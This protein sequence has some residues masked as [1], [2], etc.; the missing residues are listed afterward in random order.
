MSLYSL[1]VLIGSIFSFIA[2]CLIYFANPKS[3]NN[4]SFSGFC[5]SLFVWLFGYVIAYSTKDEKTAL[6]FCRIAC[7]GAV[8]TAPT[9]YHFA[10]SFL[11]KRK[12]IK[13]V[14]AAYLAMLFIAP[15][16]LT[17]N[18]FLRG[19]YKYYWG[20]YSKAGILHPLYLIIFFGIF[21]RG[22]YILLIEN[23]K[24]DSSV[25]PIKKVQI[26]YIFIAYAVALMGAI[27][28]V[29]KY[30]V[31]LFPFGFLF[32]ILFVI[33]VAYAIKTR[34]ILNINIALIRTAIFILVYLAALG[35]PLFLGIWGRPFLSEKVGVN[36][37]VLPSLLLAVMAASGSFVFIFLRKKVESTFLKDKYR[38]HST[39]IEAARSITLIR[40]LHK[41]LNLIVRILTST[42]KI[43]YASIYLR[44]IEKGQYGF[45]VTRGG[46]QNCAPVDFGNSLVKYL[47]IA[48]KPI[49][50]EELKRDYSDR[51]DIFIKE[52]IDTMNRLSAD[53]LVPS[54]I[55]DTLI[56][57]LVL[58]NKRSGEM[59]TSEDLNVLSNLAN[60]SALAI[61]NA[62]FLKEREEV[63][64]KLR[65]A[66]TLSTI[67]DLL[68]SFN[69]EI[70]NLLTPISGTLQGI[71]MG[72][73]E[74]RPERLKPDVEKS[75]AITFFIKTYLNW[76]REYVESGD[77]VAAYQLSE[78]INGGISYSKERIE[79]Q[80]IKT[81]VN[82][83]PKIFIVGYESIPLIFRHLIIHSVYG[84]G[85]EQG[86]TINITARILEDEATV[87]II[88]S[89]TGD[90]LTKYIEEGSTM[91]G[92]RFAEKGKLGGT[93]YFI[94]Q[95]V[96]SKHNGFFKVEPTGGKGT[97]YIVRLPLDF[98]KVSV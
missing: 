77:K 52:M 15:F 67:R 74:K 78:L 73:Y 14:I 62:Q 16:S 29:P 53:M 42:L 31:E 57:F 38:T 60:Q 21:F 23:W 6:L 35:T 56:G 45:C 17:S 76:V 33:I 64:A 26:N 72:D 71:N 61:E 36:W 8:F 95:A 18:L 50:L 81:Q 87:E 51:R 66:Q 46:K 1:P 68:G 75:I 40:D 7:T 85:M 90:D 89:D 27:D 48:R 25:D 32:E 19:V 2:G 41:L 80:S 79:K 10:V 69:H 20:Y 9:F 93:S 43:K 11:N 3:Q 49:I 28:Y 92:T 44:D 34:N 94:V 91:G 39:L 70:Y 58:G 84:Y 82:I 5:F 96:V 98:N 13:F 59:Y 88:Q 22:F 47:K 4:I 24:K 12:E 83:N 97:K 54:F 30:G 55:E 86:G 65:D 63:Q 37:W